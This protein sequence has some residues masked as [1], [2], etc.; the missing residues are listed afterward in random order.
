MAIKH[1]VTRG[2]IGSDSGIDFVPTLGFSVGE[3]AV[4]SVPGIE[5]ALWGERSHFAVA[6]TRSQFALD[7]SRCHFSVPE[8]EGMTTLVQ[9]P[10][11]AVGDVDVVAIDFTDYLDSGELL[12]GT[13]TVAEVTSSDLTLGNKAVSTASLT[14]LGNTVVTGAAVQFSIQGQQSGLDYRVRVTATTDATVARTKVV[15][16]IFHTAVQES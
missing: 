15:D 16:L 9:E 12:T 2:F 6:D 5:M 4:I 14:I 11:L 13:P 7:E 8:E 3:V 1:V 10:Q